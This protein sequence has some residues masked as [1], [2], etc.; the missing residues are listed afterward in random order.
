MLVG[1]MLVGCGEGG[2]GPGDSATC[3]PTIDGGVLR[4]SSPV[5]CVYACTA[6]AAVTCSVPGDGGQST[7][8]CTYLR[9]DP[10]NC[11]NCDVRCIRTR[12]QGG[13][14]DG[15]CEQGRCR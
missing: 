11:G 5:A 8:V 9:S 12:D 1:L 4:A 7:Q 14:L 3:P 6:D 15:I 10:Q 2:G 13:T